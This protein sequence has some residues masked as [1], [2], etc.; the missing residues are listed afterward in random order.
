MN[1]P[2]PSLPQQAG[3]RSFLRVGG[4]VLVIVG[5]LLTLGG[6]AS[7]FSAF[8]SFGAAPTNFWMAFIGLPMLAI[9]AA[10]LRAGYLGPASR[11]VAG[12]VTPVLRDS[13]GALGAGPERRLCAACGAENDA[14]A[15]FC[16]RCGQ[17]LSRRCAACGANNDVDAGFCDSCGAALNA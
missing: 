6:L 11:Y 8:G 7:F 4:V 5:G 15:G 12:E 1:R 2:D 17:P 9:G 16:D 13:L 10:M 14:D 3:V